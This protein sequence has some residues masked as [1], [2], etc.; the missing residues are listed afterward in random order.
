[1]KIAMLVEYFYPF[2]RGGSEI[3]TLNL[4]KEL[5]RKC[6]ISIITPNYGA[7]NKETIDK[8]KIIRFSFYKKLK[9]KK[10]FFS[11]F[12]TNN[13]FWFLYSA[14]QIIK[15][16]SGEKIDVI[17]IQSKSFIPGAY[18]AN[19]VLK[20][21][22]I[23][24][25][26]DYQ[27]ICN[28]GFCLL[29]K[30]KS[31]NLLEYLFFDVPYFLKNYAKGVPLQWLFFP[32]FA[33]RAR[34]MDKLINFA[35]KSIKYKI[36]ISH[37][38]RKIFIRNGFKNIDVINNTID[39]KKIKIKKTNKII[40]VGK[41]TPAKGILP[42][43]KVMLKIK[44]INFKVQ[45]IGKGILENKIRNL[46]N[47]S[48][49]RNKFEVINY[50]EHK[51]VLKEIALAKLII[52]PSIW[53]E[54]FGRVA[55][56]ALSVLTPLVVSKVG[57]LPEIVKDHVYGRVASPEPKVFVKAITEVYKNSKFYQNKIQDDYQKIYFKY[58]SEPVSKYVSLYKGSVNK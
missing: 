58:N 35:A 32:I 17:H 12:H 30:D 24:T 54:P 14:F 19:F 25:F 34:L 47:N 48:S 36:C 13:L 1:M 10:T 15:I 21:P 2:D 29:K 50:L 49:N 52:V 37:R 33:L 55:I 6:D 23:V 31:C 11:P 7:K 26:R 4:A 5:S 9:K 8:V 3:S 57:G 45:I 22:I 38:Q 43:I 51:E 28:L 20:K 44:V 42:I 41:L 56:E 16:V 46:I 53:Q 40:Y 18:L 39:F 27:P